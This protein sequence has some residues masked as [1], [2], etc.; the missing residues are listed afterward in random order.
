MSGIKNLLEQ[1][2]SFSIG[3]YTLNGREIGQT[4]SSYDSADSELNAIAATGTFKGQKVASAEL[5][6]WNDKTFETEQ[7][8]GW[9]AD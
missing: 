4:F 2:T 7:L 1:F 3:C 9:C 6:G 8:G 5:F